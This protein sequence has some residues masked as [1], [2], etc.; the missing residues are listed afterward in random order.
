MLVIYSE[1]PQKSLVG[2]GLG[3]EGRARAGLW[4]PGREGRAG[5]EEGT[6]REPPH[7]ALC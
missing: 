2:T 1:L 4:C 7:L 5:R 3:G 6:R